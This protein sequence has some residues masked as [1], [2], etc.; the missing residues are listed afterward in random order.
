MHAHD[1][2]HAKPPDLDSSVVGPL[3][4]AAA[5]VVAAAVLVNAFIAGGIV[6]SYAAYVVWTGDRGE[7]RSKACTTVAVVVLVVAIG[8]FAWGVHLA[9]K[10][11]NAQ[12][13]VAKQE[14]KKTGAM[15]ADAAAPTPLEREADLVVSHS[16][17]ETVESFIEDFGQPVLKVSYGTY[18]IWQ[19]KRKFEYIHLVINRAG[20]PISYGI[21]ARDATFRP[22]FRTPFDVTLNK[23]PVH[24]RSA[25]AFPNGTGVA[26]CGTQRSGYFE[27]YGGPYGPTD[28]RSAILGA[29]NIYTADPGANAVICNR[30][31]SGHG[32]GVCPS[33]LYGGLGHGFVRCLTGRRA[34]RELERNVISM[35]YVET[36]KY[37]RVVPAMIVTP[38]V[39][40]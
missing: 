14:I 27:G 7:N 29:A 37:Q 20:E 3:V 16:A 26:Y 34:G 11:R 36:A 12:P 32:L 17:G 33:P 31:L 13:G 4:G 6:C 39:I 38:D 28:G 2:K 21:F 30:L 8:C 23:T 1:R 9:A 22:R 19:F 10:S 24:N 25:L 15:H 18:R 5:G 35:I 40:D